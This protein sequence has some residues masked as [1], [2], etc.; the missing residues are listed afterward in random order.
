M[1][2]NL[3]R[4]ETKVYQEDKVRNEIECDIS[5]A[6]YKA[7]SLS[8]QKFQTQFTSTKVRSTSRVNQN[9]A[10]DFPGGF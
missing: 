3:K 5:N 2:N 9:F 8:I 6:M 1:Y 7:N 10:E 4:A